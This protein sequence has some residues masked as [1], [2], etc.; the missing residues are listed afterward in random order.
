MQINRKMLG[1]MPALE[2]DAGGKSPDTTPDCLGN[3][4]FHVREA[5]RREQAGERP[6]SPSAGA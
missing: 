4:F 2:K 1:V 3:E 6:S 5:A